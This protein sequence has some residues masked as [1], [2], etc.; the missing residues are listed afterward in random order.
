M[1]IELVPNNNTRVRI[2]AVQE[3][4]D[5]GELEPA[6]G[7]VMTIRV[8]EN[9]TSTTAIGTLSYTATEF[10][11]KLGDYTAMILGTDIQSQLEANY[12]DTPVVVQ[13][14]YGTTIR[15]YVDAIVR[16]VRSL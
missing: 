4:E 15:G 9:A 11:L 14:V 1:A 7:L 10:P 3:N 13:L 5:S 8:A 6:S 16:P 2:K 12:M